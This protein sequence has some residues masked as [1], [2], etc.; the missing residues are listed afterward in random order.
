[1]D[2]ESKI[3]KIEGKII[4]AQEKIKKGSPEGDP[5]QTLKIILLFNDH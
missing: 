3:R 1:V 2:G 5:L 4:C